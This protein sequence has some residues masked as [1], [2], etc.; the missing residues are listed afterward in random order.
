MVEIKVVWHKYPD[1][2]SVLSAIIMTDYLNKKWYNAKPYILW[3]LNKETE[4]LLNLLN[5]EKPD[6]ANSFSAWTKVCLVDHNEKSQTL[7]NLD[8]LHVD[9]VIDHHKINF[10]T[11]DPTYIRV[12]PLCST[13]S[14]L[15]KI[16]KE[17]GFDIDEKNAKMMLFCILSDSLM[18]KS[19]T[20]TNEDI[21]IAE[22]LKILSWISNVE[23]YALAMFDAKSNLWDISVEK[24]IKYDYKEFDFNWIKA[25]I[26]TLETTNPN[27]ALWRKEEILL[28]MNSIKEKDSIDFIF[29][30]IIDI[31]KEKSIWIILAWDDTWIV[32]K[33][34]DCKME[35]NLIDLKWRLSR[36]KEIVPDLTE[37][38]NNK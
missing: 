28:W 32:E 8:E 12:E 27:Y 6:F 13:G 38:F 21:K 11:P 5:I 22:E 18:F 25:W 36:K 3:E 15:Y 16:Y 37:Y 1:T 26:W 9:Y 2:D 19:P 17:A 29:L 14:I 24:L 31:I 33:V 30:I 20:T 34:F 35:N 23:K 7:D 10:E 4:Y